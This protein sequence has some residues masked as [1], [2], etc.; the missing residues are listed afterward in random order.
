MVWCTVIICSVISE[1][2]GC[3]QNDPR[4]TSCFPNSGWSAGEFQNSTAKLRNNFYL[5]FYHQH[6]FLTEL[7]SHGEL[8]LPAFFHSATNSIPIKAVPGFYSHVTVALLCTECWS[9]TVHWCQGSPEHTKLTVAFPT[10]LCNLKNMLLTFQGAPST[11]KSLSFSS[12]TCTHT[13]T[14]SYI[15][16]MESVSSK[17]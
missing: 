3:S 1:E 5:Y 9:N 2:S 13:K 16:V 15:K 7:P 14:R 12:L 4:N 11:P 10:G 6:F 8:I 17:S